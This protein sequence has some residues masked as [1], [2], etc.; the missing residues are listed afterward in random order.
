V[1]EGDEQGRFCRQSCT[2][3]GCRPGY[4]CHENENPDYDGK[5]SCFPLCLTDADCSRDLG[6]S[7]GCN[8]WS[9]RCELKDKGGRKYGLSCSGPA[10]CESGVCLPDR[11]GYCAGYCPRGG[12]CAT[13]GACGSDGLNDQT[14]RCFDVCAGAADCTR[15]APYQC[16][17][18]PYGGTSSNVCYC[19]RTGEPCSQNSD[20]CNPSIGPIQ[21]CTFGLCVL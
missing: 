13:D 7:Y 8:L 2:S 16:A 1:C 12:T 15:G 3:G 11:G 10:D 5:R 21:A 17:A 9:R 19:R 18:A 20:C 14:A 4:A 6:A